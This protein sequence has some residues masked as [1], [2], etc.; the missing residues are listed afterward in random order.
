MDGYLR[1]G[2]LSRR[3]GVSPELLRAWEQRYRLL[4]PGRSDGGFR[5]YS[6]RDEQRVRRM[7]A[8]IDRGVAAAEAARDVLAGAEPPPSAATQ[9][10]DSLLE[11][12]G[13]DLRAALDAIDTDRAHR[14]F[15]RI[16]AA[17]S[18]HAALRDLVLPFLRDLGD[19]WEAGEV[20]VAQEHFASSLIR[21]RLMGIARD[22]GS[23][24]GP[25]AVLACP[26]GES[27]ELGLIIF[28]IEL[29]RYGWRITYLGADTPVST[30]LDT[31]RASLPSLVVLAVTDAAR[32]RDHATELRSLAAIVP[33]AVGGWITPAD[34]RLLGAR[35]LEGDPLEAARTVAGRD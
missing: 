28:G 31:A 7:T 1:I 22:W 29:A 35:V 3:T 27:H 25:V 8:L 5:L 30:L 12:L 16:F 21:G 14:A 6:D 26:P 15:D 33:L 32:A 19:R 4:E 11:E 2:E 23:G 20:S 9:A 17:L 24:S 18:V 10:S 34:A 13:R